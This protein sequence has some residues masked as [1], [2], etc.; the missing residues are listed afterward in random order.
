MKRL[1][2]ML[3]LA[4]LAL[5]ATAAPALAD[6]FSEMKAGEAYVHP[7]GGTDPAWWEGVDAEGTTSRRPTPSPRATPC[8][9]R[10]G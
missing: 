6:Y 2:I 5:G 10:R 9:W 1:I 3:A 8:I 7:W 4:V